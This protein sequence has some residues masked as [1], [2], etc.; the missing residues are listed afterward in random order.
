VDQLQQVEM[1][2]QILAAA[3]VLV[4]V[5]LSLLVEM[6]DLELLL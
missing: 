1:V 5:K 4:E 3:A 2:V 6:V